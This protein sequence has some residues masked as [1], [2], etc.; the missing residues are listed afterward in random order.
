[1]EGW[2]VESGGQEEWLVIS[3]RAIPLY[4]LHSFH[5]VVRYLSVPKA[6]V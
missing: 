6:I 3:H 5:S 4:L 1:M 2:F